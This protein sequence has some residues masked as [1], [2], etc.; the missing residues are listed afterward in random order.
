MQFFEN[1][2]NN[3]LLPQPSIGTNFFYMKNILPN[4]NYSEIPENDSYDSKYKTELCKKFMSTGK[5]PY[6]YKCRF[7]HGKEE[8]ISKH[9]GNNYKKKPCKSFYNKGYCPYG[10]RCSFKHDEKSFYETN[11]SY[12]YLQTF[13]LN[14]TNFPSSTLNLNKDKK[15]THKEKRLSVFIDL[16]N[17][18]ENKENEN[19]NLMM[20]IGMEKSPSFSPEIN[21]NSKSTNLEHN[22]SM[23]TISIDENETKKTDIKNDEEE[24]KISFNFNLN[25]EGFIEENDG[26]KSQ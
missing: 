20:M 24:H 11:L 8:L 5:C 25:L 14:Y 6:G 13:L 2:K 12:F 10:S 22:S 19:D 9:L 18:K 23:S 17:E 1:H 21:L 4:K 16:M 26:K 7:A 15:L 3:I